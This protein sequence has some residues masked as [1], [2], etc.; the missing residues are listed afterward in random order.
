[1][2]LAPTKNIE[3]RQYAKQHKVALWEIADKEGISDFT[4][5]RRMRREFDESE[6]KRLIKIIDQIVKER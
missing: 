2:S 6:K 3:L 4:F 1:M 5:S